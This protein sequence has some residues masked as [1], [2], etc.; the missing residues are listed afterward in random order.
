MI[1]LDGM[2]PLPEQLC[3]GCVHCANAVASQSVQ[4]KSTFEE[5][6]SAE[7]VRHANILH[8]GHQQS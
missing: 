6:K 4:A 8:E 1:V 7:Y 2:E 5:M 3:L